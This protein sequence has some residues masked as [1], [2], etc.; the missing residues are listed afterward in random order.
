MINP[1]VKYKGLE[2]FGT[3][4]LM[5]G[6]MGFEAPGERKFTQLA[7]EIV[8]RFLPR[9][10]CYIGVRYNTVKGTPIFMQ[11]EITINRATFAAGW[12][13]TRNIELKAE[14]VNQQYKDFPSYDYHYNGK[15]SGMVMEAAVAF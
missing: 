9:E 14:Y 11:N 6:R 3:Y 7:G 8:Y 2:F 5:K 1:F 4:E 12:F 10:Q 15:F 13:P